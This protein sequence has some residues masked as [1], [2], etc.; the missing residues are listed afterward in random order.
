[1]RKR[2]PHKFIDD[3]EHKFCAHCN[4]GEGEWHPLVNFNKKKASYD[5]LETKCKGCTKKKSKKYRQENPD[6][7]REYQEK[8]KEALRAYKREYYRR[9]HVKKNEK[10][11]NV[12]SES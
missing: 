4:D 2:L 6:Y 3:V 5:G 12:K 7:D 11:D 1:M 10:S 9:K 8:N